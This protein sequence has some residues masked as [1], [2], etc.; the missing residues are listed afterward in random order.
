MRSDVNG[1][2]IDNLRPLDGEAVLY[3]T[4]TVCG[5]SCHIFLI[6]VDD[7]EEEGATLQRAVCDPYGRFDDLLQ[8]DENVTAFATVRVHGFPGDYVFFLHPHER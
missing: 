8:L 5:V 6:R 3:G 2:L 4:T 7:V 1:T